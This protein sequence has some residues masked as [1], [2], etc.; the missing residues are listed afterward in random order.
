MVAGHVFAL[1]DRLCWSSS[2]FCTGGDPRIERVITTCIAAKI[3]RWDKTASAPA[4]T[5]ALLLFLSPIWDASEAELIHV[6]FPWNEKASWSARLSS[7]ILRMRIIALFSN[8]TKVPLPCC[9]KTFYMRENLVSERTNVNRTSGATA[10]IIY[11]SEEGS[12]KLDSAQ[13][14]FQ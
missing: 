10:R 9:E 8:A 2:L 5:L 3:S 6:A 14:F 4:A 1:F 7:P 13:S 12:R 11:S